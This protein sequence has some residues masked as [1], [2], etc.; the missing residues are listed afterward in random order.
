MRAGRDAYEISYGAI[1]GSLRPIT[2]YRVLD[3]LPDEFIH[4][5]TVSPQALPA[6]TQRRAA[7]RLGTK[8]NMLL[9]L[10]YI[11]P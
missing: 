9:T 6:R 10:G 7:H 5:E 8:E 2:P 4:R 3:P 11:R 1:D